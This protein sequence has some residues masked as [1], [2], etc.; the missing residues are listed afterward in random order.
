MHWKKCVCLLLILPLPLCPVAVRGENL[1]TEQGC[2]SMDAPYAREGYEDFP[3]EAKAAFVYDIESDTVLYSH[4]P[5]GQVYPASTTKLLT[6][7]VALD[8]CSPEDQRVMT[9]TALNAV[10]EDA[11]SAWQR[12]GP[13]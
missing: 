4:N 6:A 10:S 1:V 3:L 12:L 2:V 11:T 8:M 13:T 7:L 9:Q 5:D